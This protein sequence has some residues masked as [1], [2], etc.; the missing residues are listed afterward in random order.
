MPKAHNLSTNRYANFKANYERLPSL[1]QENPHAT[2]G[3]TKFFD[4]SLEEMR[5][6]F[7]VALVL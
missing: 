2:F 4:L 5:R 6:Y 3:V 7:V 1:R